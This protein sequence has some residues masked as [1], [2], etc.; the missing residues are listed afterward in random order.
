MNECTVAVCLDAFKFD[1][2]SRRNTPF[3]HQMA[4][5]GIHGRLETILGYT[6]I[7]AT[8]FSGVYPEEHDVWEMFVYDPKNS[9]FKWFEPLSP[10]FDKIDIIPKARC[11]LRF[12]V[13]AV[14][15][16]L[17]YLSGH[18]YI[19]RIQEIPFSYLKYF[20]FSQTRAICEPRSL[21]K[22]PTIFDVLREKGIDFVYIDYPVFYFKRRLHLLFPS[23]Y[24]DEFVFEKF[25]QS[26]KSG[27][28]FY[29]LHI[30]ELD[31]ITHKFGTSSRETYKKIKE[32]DSLVEDLVYILHKNFERVNI[33]IFSDHGMV[34]VSKTVDILHKLDGCGLEAEKDYLPFIGS[35]I[36][37]FWLKDEKT[38]R[39]MTYILDEIKGGRVLKKQDLNKFRLRFRNRKHGDLIFLAD[40]GIFIAPNFFQ[41]KPEF[42]AMHG[43]DPS[44]PDQY[45]IFILSSPKIQGGSHLEKIRMVDISP[46]LLKLMSLP[47]SFQKGDK[48]VF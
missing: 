29:Y 15:N 11:W 47:F 24:S 33:L 44:H 28:K 35:T 17:R 9:P 38:K 7:N 8:A 5:E 19:E 14:S 25:R 20:N 1:Y 23:R 45:G 22:V 31:K 27:C 32:V 41:R 43:Y 18:S 21:G 12:G 46:T 3:L 16:A 36:A 2:L 39:E 4:N 10:L 26:L 40:P 30:W 13:S 34:N 37:R 42:K 48:P 6:G